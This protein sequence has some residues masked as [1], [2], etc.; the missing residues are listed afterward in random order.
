MSRHRP[1]VAFAL[2]SAALNLGLSIALIGPLGVRGVA[3]GTLVATA[4][5][6]VFVVPFAMRV[7]RIGPRRIVTQALLPSALPI[8]PMAG[9]LL[10]I[11]HGFAPSSLPAIA[12]A[13]L[14]GACAY[15]LC[16][17]AFPA[18]AGER[19]VA[20]GMFASGLTLTRRL[21]ARPRA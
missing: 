21:L 14:A 1:L 2:G 11:R 7:L 13:G 9:V 3:I 12:L 15:T 16:Y 20:R 8:L 17:L 10:A 4:C 5:E 18:T 19:A 6:A